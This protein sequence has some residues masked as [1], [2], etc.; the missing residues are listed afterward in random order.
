LRTLENYRHALLTFARDHSPTTP[1]PWQTLS[2]DDFRLHL[3]RFMKAEKGRATIR[4]N[5]A[6]TAV[7]AI[8]DRT[9]SVA[10]CRFRTLGSHAEQ[11]IDARRPKRRRRTYS[12]ASACACGSVTRNAAP[13]CPGR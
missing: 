3:F 13:P 9:P 12:A 8:A 10:P 4:R 2:A 1:C 7:P 5:A 6:F 11:R